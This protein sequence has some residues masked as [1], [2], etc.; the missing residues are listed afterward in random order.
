MYIHKR[1]YIAEKDFKSL[2]VILNFVVTLWVYFNLRIILTLR[3][4]RFFNPDYA[5]SH[6]AP[7][8]GHIYQYLIGTKRK[9]II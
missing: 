2:D 4:G 1:R 3:S 9:D 5:L 8:E 7:S 6:Q